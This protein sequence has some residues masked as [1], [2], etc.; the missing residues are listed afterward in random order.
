MKLKMNLT[1]LCCLLTLNCASYAK[2]AIVSFDE[3]IEL[4]DIIVHCKVVAITKKILGKDRVVVEVIQLIKGDTKKKIMNIGYGESILKEEGQRD[5][6]TLG[7]TYILFLVRDKRKSQIL[8]GFQGVYAIT[9]DNQVIDSKGDKVSV[10][11]FI[12]RIQD[13]RVQ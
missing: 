2:M 9:N 8:G 3:Q 11:K 1:C 5:R 7:R 13:H 6:F 4:A 10:D 12:E